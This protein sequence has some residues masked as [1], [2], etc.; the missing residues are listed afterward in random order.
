[1]FDVVFLVAV[2][3]IILSAT[4]FF[5]H[6]RRVGRIFDLAEREIERDFRRREASAPAQVECSHCGNR[7]PAG[8]DC[9]SCGARL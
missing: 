6:R 9:P 8:E 5:R 7:G 4:S 1:M 2:G 3:I